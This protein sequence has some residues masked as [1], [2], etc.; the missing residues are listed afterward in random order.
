MPIVGF[1]FDKVSANKSGTVKGKIDIAHNI[2]IKDVKQEEL[3]LDKK[4]NVLRFTFEF[5]VD[6]KPNLG[7]ISLEGHL[8]Y[9]DTPEKIKELGDAWK[10]NKKLPDDI[11][12]NVI[13]MVLTKSNVK[14]LILSQDV[15]LPPQIQL[16][17][18]MPP[19][20]SAENYIG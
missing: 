6:Y 7:D 4:Q 8:L 19:K 12:T 14:A 15:N 17:K 2:N 5:K 1:Q 11:T 9:L 18:A 3:T 13:N 10:K 16:P 20:Q